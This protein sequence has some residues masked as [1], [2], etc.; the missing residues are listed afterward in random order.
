MRKLAILTFTIAL[1]VALVAAQTSPCAGGTYGGRRNVV[2]CVA[3]TGLEKCRRDSPYWNYWWEGSCDIWCCPGAGYVSNNCQP[4]T[5]TSNC[6][7]NSQIGQR[8]LNSP[9]AP[10][11]APDS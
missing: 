2:E 1:G 11:C 9:I 6:C 3:P 4:F 7:P 5:R 10:T 8:F